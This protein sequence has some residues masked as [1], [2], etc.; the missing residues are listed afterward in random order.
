MIKRG[1]TTVGQL[2]LKKGSL[3]LIGITLFGVILWSIDISRLWAVVKDVSIPYL[4]LGFLMGF[5]VRYARSFRWNRI[6]KFLDIDVTPSESF[7]YQLISGMAL[8]TP[9]KLGEF[10]KAFY[11]KSRSF[12]FMKSTVSVIGDRVFDVLISLIVAAVAS[13]YFLPVDRQWTRLAA[14]GGP[15]VCLIIAHLVLSNRAMATSIGRP[16]IEKLLPAKLQPKVRE[17]MSSLIDRYQQLT[18]TKLSYFSV[19]SIIAFYFQI[20]RFQVLTTALGFSVSTAVM[21]GII[22]IMAISNL[23]PITFSGLGTRDA[24]FWYCFQQIGINPEYAIGLSMLVLVTNI[25]NGLLGTA[26]FTSFPPAMDVEQ[27]KQSLGSNDKE[28]ER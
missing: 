2:L 13:F 12:S 24:V 16:V 11:L 7:F 26:L 27:F 17:L 8:F 1:L 15:I 21:G 9:A 22:G 14:V 20:L 25:L 3:R 23:L 18:L 19:L 4:I 10:V 5:P 6:K 28:Q